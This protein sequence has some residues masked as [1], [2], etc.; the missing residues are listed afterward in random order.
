MK[1]VVDGIDIFDMPNAG[2]ECCRKRER[3]HERTLEAVSS[4][5]LFGNKA[6]VIRNIQEQYHCAF[7]LAW[8]VARDILLSAIG[9][10]FHKQIAG[11]SP[12]VNRN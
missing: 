10:C 1:K 7:H 2:Y 8:Q 4:M 9:S 11:I 12:A 6:Q 3:G 5:P